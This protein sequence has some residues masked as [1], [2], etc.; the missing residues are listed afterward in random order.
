MVMGELATSADVVVIGAGPGG[1]VAAIRAAQLGRKV[2]LVDKNDELGGIC[3]NH[4]CIPS[5]ALISASSFAKRIETASL[6]GII[7]PKPKI[8]AKQLQKWKQD[9]IDKLVNGIKGL[10]SKHKIEYIPGKAQFQSSK[11]LRINS[12]EGHKTINFKHCIIATGSSPTEIKG[13]EFDEKTILSSTGALKLDK[14]PKSLVV[15]GGGYI[16]CELGTVYAKLG[17]KVTIIQRRDQVLPFLSKDITSIVEHH[18]EDLGIEILFGASAEGAKV[19]KGGAEVS[20]THNGKKKTLKTDKVLVAVGRRPNSKGFGLEKTKVKVNE[21]GFIEVD[22]QQRT[23]DSRIL[24]IGDVVPGAALAH[25]A[26]TEGKVAA[27]VIAGKKDA[28]DQQIPNVIFTDPEIATVGLNETQAK[29]QG[30]EVKVGKFPYMANG[31][32]LTV[33]ANSGFVKIIADK[34]TDVVLGVFIVGHEASNLISEANLA[35]EMG[36]TTED[37]ALTIHP[38]PTLPETIMEASEAV[39]NAAIH[40]YQSKNT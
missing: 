3:L 35:V 2:I 23:S 15:I 4:G 17:S 39:N 34:K 18:M 9:V 33:N 28:F 7:V 30:Y 5:K 22:K 14:V 32:A 19:T 24:A 20:I 27:A 10:L 1:Y 31:R 26:S 12:G 8:D 21:K 25:K 11:Q 37:L 40:I 29:E 13:F 36:A 6:M 16:G 38:H